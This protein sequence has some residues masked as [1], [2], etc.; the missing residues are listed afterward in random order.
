MINPPQSIHKLDIKVGFQIICIVAKAQ[1]TKVLRDSNLLQ[2]SFTI[3]E[4]SK[5]RNHSLFIRKS[6]S[7]HLPNAEP[8]LILLEAY[9]FHGDGQIPW[10]LDQ[11]FHPNCLSSGNSRQSLQQIHGSAALPSGLGDQRW[12]QLDQK[13]LIQSPPRSNYINQLCSILGNPQDELC[14]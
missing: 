13:F 14:S 6:F 8:K 10:H 12:Q 5:S 9:K 1:M 2:H 7:F 3:T 4:L 11:L